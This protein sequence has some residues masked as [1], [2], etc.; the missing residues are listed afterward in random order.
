MGLIEL[1]SS[2]RADRKI[3]KLLRGATPRS[4]AELREGSFQRVIGTVQPHRARVLE[5]PLSG[6]LCAYYSIVVRGPMTT[7]WSIA[8]RRAGR[9]Y[10]TYGEDEDG[11]PFELE[12]GDTRAIVDPTNAWISSGFDHQS[13]V[14]DD[15]ARI[16]VNRIGIQPQRWANILVQEAILGVGERIAVFGAGVFE[17]DRTA[18]AGEQ[19]YREAG[20]MRFRFS[21]TEKFPLVIRDDL[22][23]L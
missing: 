1:I 17:P 3:K 12:A 13:G 16:V 14:S 22:Q 15:R 19:G 11:V 8:P 4:I 2:L 6:R 18:T 10:L 5:A 23:D 7:S 21:G 20:A 9:I